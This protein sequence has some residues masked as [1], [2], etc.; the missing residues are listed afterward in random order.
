MPEVNIDRSLNAN[1]QPE[2][3]V[4]IQNISIR[5][6]VRSSQ[7]ISKWR[8]ALVAAEAINPIRVPLLDLYAD[9][10][11]DG[12]LSSLIE[13]RLLGVTKC[14][15]VFFNKAGEKD[16]DVTK[17]FQLMNFRKM[18]KK[19]LEYKFYGP[20]AIELIK[21]KDM[22]R[23]FAPDRKHVLPKE[24]KIVYEQYGADGFYYR[25]PPYNK[26]VF[27]TG[28]WNEH[29]LLLKAAQ[30]VIYKRGGF[31]DWA[32]FAEIFG[33]PFR[34]GTYDGYNDTTRL[35]LEKALEQ[36]G[37]ASW[38]VKPTGSNIEFLES[39]N[40]QGSGNLYDGLRKACNEEMSILIL[41][42]TGTT[43]QTAGKLGNEDGNNQTEDDINF[44][45]KLDELSI[46]NELVLPILLNLGY[47]VDGGLIS[48][49][50]EEDKIPLDKLV[51]ILM[52][53]RNNLKLPIDDDYIYEVTKVPKPA[54]Y[55]EIKAKQ[56]A[57]AAAN[58]NA[59][60]DE[61]TPQNEKKKGKTAKPANKLS[62]WEQFRL[63]MADFF[64]QARED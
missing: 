13:K 41:G 62:K 12:T 26:Y 4:V 6:A 17:L 8:S 48:Y 54:N 9:I 19:A 53:L 58:T 11:L 3:G 42:Q 36:A 33:M 45:D 28:E 14:K 46:L 22:F 34:V 24:G 32:N 61:D 20:A 40:T 27:E 5:P 39:K 64:D 23:F 50:V 31:G 44:N 51:T 55:N 16:E 63:T 1:L 59:P 52:Q 38:I 43:I 18:R 25:Q 15:L 35:Q 29:G 2:K 10:I 49:D 7:D 57:E 21:E 47:P 30:Y 60:D 56:E 37:N